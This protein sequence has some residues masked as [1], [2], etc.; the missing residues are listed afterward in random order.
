[1]VNMTKQL[2]RRAVEAHRRGEQWAVFWEQHGDDVRAVEPWNRGRFHCLVDRLLALVVSG[3]TDGQQPIGDDD[4]MSWELDDQVSPHDSKTQARCLL[5]LRPM[6][7]G[8]QGNTTV[9]VDCSLCHQATSSPERTQR[10]GPPLVV[11]SVQR[12]NATDS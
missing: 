12:K 5:P 3:D 11:G 9:D 8:K 6:P 10:P 1:M 4:A 7:E 2:E